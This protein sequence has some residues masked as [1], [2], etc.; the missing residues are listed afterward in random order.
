VHYPAIALLDESAEKCRNADE[1][2]GILIGSYR[3]PH[4]E[5][6]SFTR[7]APGDERRRYSFVR[8][9][10]VHQMTA[11][12]AWQESGETTTFIGEWHTHPYGAPVPSGTD[13]SS[14]FELARNAGNAMAFA[15][16]APEHWALY[17]VRP[18]IFSLREKQL[19]RTSEGE[20]GAVFEIKGRL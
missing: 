3:G 13:K 18:G 12:K 1:D 17:L 8:Q 20:L 9:D 7:S 19:F 16:V 10:S 14:W 5:I 4:L 15:V 6:T 2:G 11:T